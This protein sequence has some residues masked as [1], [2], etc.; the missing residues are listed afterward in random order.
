MQFQKGLS[1]PEFLQ[2]Y[3]TETQSEDAPAKI[4]WPNGFRCS[5]C[6]ESLHGLVDGRRLKRYQCR[7]YG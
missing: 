7:Q 5:R 1:V 4:C 6:E 2:L 3:V